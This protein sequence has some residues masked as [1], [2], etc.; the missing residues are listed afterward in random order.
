MG[1]VESLMYYRESLM[2]VTSVYCLSLI[3]MYLYQTINRQQNISHISKCILRVLVILPV[4]IMVGYRGFSTGADTE[5]YWLN[6]FPMRDSSLSTTIGQSTG[7]DILFRFLAWSICKI[8]NAN[9][10]VYFTVVAALTLYFVILTIDKWKLRNSTTALFLFLFCFGPNLCNQMREL[11]AVSIMLYAYWYLYEKKRK[12]FILWSVVA[13]LI[14]LSALAAAMITYFIVAFS[15]KQKKSNTFYIFLGLATVFCQPI[16]RFLGALLFSGTKYYNKYFL[17][18]SGMSVGLGMLLTM[19]PIVIPAFVM[20]RRLD[21]E[22]KILKII[23]VAIP[24]RLVGY[25]YYFVS[26]MHY[27]F[28][29]MGIVG[30]PMALDNTPDKNRGFTRIFIIIMVIAYYLAFYFWK[31]AS[32]YFPYVFM[33]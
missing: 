25:D 30:L 9:V 14:H 3:L 2:T 17:E 23:S 6:Y 13:S 12:V 19:I 29:G 28:S 22:G 15:K 31:D 26:R 7:G 27:Y 16:T 24:A 21:K 10:H 1:F 32:T 5:N 4:A 33:S 18:A 20:H 11:L 8:T